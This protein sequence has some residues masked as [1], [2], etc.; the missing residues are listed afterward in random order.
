[1]GLGAPVRLDRRQLEDLIEYGASI[2]V[3]CEWFQGQVDRHMAE[4]QAIGGLE[5]A[6][7]EGPET[8]EE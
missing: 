4:E 2:D 3:I 7:E 5:I 1:M 8:G 6:L